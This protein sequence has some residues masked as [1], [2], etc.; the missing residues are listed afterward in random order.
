MNFQSYSSNAHNPPFSPPLQP[1]PFGPP[2]N[3]KAAL[4]IPQKIMPILI[5][6]GALPIIFKLRRQQGLNILRIGRKHEPR[7]ALAGLDGPRVRRIA[8]LG[9]DAE[10]EL[11]VAVGERARDGV[12]QQVQPQRQIGP[13][14]GRAGAQ[15][16]DAAR[17][18][19]VMDECA[20]EVHGEEGEE[21]VG[22]R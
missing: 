18:E 20:E 21:C 22:Y 2:S 5:K 19:R 14:D 8:V 13:A 3:G 12:V 17:F 7:D 10:P 4:T 1:N 11:V 16:P 9:E 6:I 15:T